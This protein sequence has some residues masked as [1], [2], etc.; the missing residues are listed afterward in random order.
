MVNASNLSRQAKTRVA[1]LATLGALH[2]E[3]LAYDLDCLRTIIV[4]LAPDLLCAEITRPDWE[5]GDLSKVTLELR[6][7][8]EPAARLTE[9]VLVPVAPS[10]ERFEDFVAPPGWR[11]SLVRTFDRWLRWGQRKAGKPQSI[12]GVL[13]ESFCHS[14]CLMTETTWSPSE[15]LAWDLQNQAL[16]EA[17][18]EVARRDPGRRVLVAVQCQR[19]HKL[20]PL[21]KKYRDEIDLVDYRDL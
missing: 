21:L 12:H 1:L 19:F 20:E 9:T 11:R 10:P 14:V 3:P 6:Q 2:A 7:A 8:L 15:R 17:I 18:L 16:A 13:F 4:E 5:N